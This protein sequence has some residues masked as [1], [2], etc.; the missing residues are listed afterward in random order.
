VWF[1]RTTPEPL[2]GARGRSKDV[3]TFGLYAPSLPLREEEEGG[4]RH[5]TLDGRLAGRFH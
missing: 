4:M 5:A 2:H 1:A 3:L